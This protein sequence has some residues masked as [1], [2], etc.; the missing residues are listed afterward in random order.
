MMCG[1]QLRFPHGAGAIAVQA[2]T[3]LYTL[4]QY[5]RSRL[6]GNTTFKPVAPRNTTAV[7]P[8]A[9]P[10]TAT[11]YGFTNSVRA[12][13]GMPAAAGGGRHC[14]DSGAGTLGFFSAGAADAVSDNGRSDAQRYFELVRPLEG[15]AKHA[16]AVKTNAAG[17]RFPPGSLGI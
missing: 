17:G 12:A 6:P 16:H 8:A 9:G 7:Q 4:Q 10:T 1:A 14:L 3:M 11:T 5:S 15:L 2:G 13:F